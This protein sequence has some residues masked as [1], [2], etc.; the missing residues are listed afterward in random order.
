M[1]YNIEI[2][3]K[4]ENINEKGYGFLSFARNLVWSMVKKLIDTATKTGIEAAKT[5]SKSCVKNSWSDWW[6]DR[7]EIGDKITSVK[8]A[9]PKDGIP[10]QEIYIPTKK[11]QQII[12][13]LRLV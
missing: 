3:N 10:S 4:N 5:A 13:D 8:K 6:F 7:N 2:Y 12:D 11:Y 9:K 1:L